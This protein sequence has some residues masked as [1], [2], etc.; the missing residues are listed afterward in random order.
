MKNMHYILIGAPPSFFYFSFLSNLVCFF[1]WIFRVDSQKVGDANTSPFRGSSPTTDTIQSPLPYVSN[2]TEQ[3][4]KTKG[5][6]RA[7]A[8]IGGDIRNSTLKNETVSH[9]SFALQDKVV[10]V[11]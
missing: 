4:I 10:F 7:Q 6:H 3:D 9:K 11:I 2:S 8:G 5:S 1:L